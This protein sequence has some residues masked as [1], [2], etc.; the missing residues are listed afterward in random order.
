MTEALFKRYAGE[1]WNIVVM[2][3][4]YDEVEEARQAHETVLRQFA[5]LNEKEGE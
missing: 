1:L 3:A 5:L 2:G 4:W